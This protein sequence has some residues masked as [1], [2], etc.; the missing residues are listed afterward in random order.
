MK[1]REK[2]VQLV[3]CIRSEGCENLEIGKVYQ[4][5]ADELAAEEG[6]LRVIDGSGKDYLYPAGYFVPIVLPQ[7]TER[8]LLALSSSKAVA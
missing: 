1:Q 5:L 2:E 4:V 8:A 7:A 3:I 6:Y